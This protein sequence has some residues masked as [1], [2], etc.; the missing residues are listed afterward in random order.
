MIVIF[1]QIRNVQELKIYNEYNDMVFSGII[2]VSNKENDTDKY[3]A[4][5][6]TTDQ[7]AKQP[8]RG[9]GGVGMHHDF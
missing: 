9:R 3:V 6:F 8:A 4:N 2:L 5:V 7:H 1:S